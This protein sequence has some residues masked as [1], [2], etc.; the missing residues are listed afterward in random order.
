MDKQRLAFLR[1]Y[2]EN[3]TG[4][5]LLVPLIQGGFEVSELMELGYEYLDI[6]VAW[7][8]LYKDG[9]F[10]TLLKGEQ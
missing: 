4:D 2:L 3:Y 8:E 7:A 10:N 5:D 1:I 9:E 6:M